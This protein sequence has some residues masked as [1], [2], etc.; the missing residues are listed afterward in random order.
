MKKF[1]ASCFSILFLLFFVFLAA[2]CGGGGGGVSAAT[3]G[4]N[5]GKKG[6]AGGAGSAPTLRINPN[7]SPTLTGINWQTIDFTVK[8]GN[9]APIKRTLNLGEIM[10]LNLSDADG[11][12]VGETIDI[13]AKIV[14]A[15]GLEFEAFS[16][17]KT[18]TAGT[19]NVVMTVGR[20]VQIQ[21]PA[22]VNLEGGATYVVATKN[23]ATLPKATT[24]EKKYFRYWQ[25]DD[26]TIIYN[27]MLSAADFATTASV[28]PVFKAPAP[29][30]ILCTDR[31]VAATAAELGGRT[32]LG[33][34]CGVSGN[35]WAYIFSL[36]E[37]TCKL[38]N[39]CLPYSATHADYNVTPVNI[40]QG[41]S[42]KAQMLSDFPNINSTSPAYQH[43]ASLPNFSDGTP[44][45]WFIPDSYIFQAYFKTNINTS[46]NAIGKTPLDSTA[47]YMTC[48]MKHDSTD[49]G[50]AFYAKIGQNVSTILNNS[51]C[52]Y[53]G[54]NA[55]KRLRA[56][57]RV[58]LP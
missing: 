42:L 14:N 12:A 16:G 55:A 2:G 5:A 50:Y 27:G 1:S 18:I 53:S 48:Q 51:Y 54:S 38:N 46:L 47:E 57:G 8:I 28:T 41:Y 26:S 19:N 52:Y 40:N 58:P 25:R 22:N 32:P 24:T 56:L 30:D 13:E 44:V 37:T 39:S 17:V 36:S 4:N 34:L 7:D 15:A 49:W 21:K 29:G 23:G 35:P 9:R 11:L 45:D 10:D 33:I 31:T 6:G 3:G 43:L 20:K